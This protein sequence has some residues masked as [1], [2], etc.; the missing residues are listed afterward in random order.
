MILSAPTILAPWITFKPMVQTL[1]NAALL[2][3]LASAISGT[4]TCHAWPHVNDDACACVPHDGRKQ[5]FGV[6]PAERE[7]V[8]VADAGGP[9]FDPHFAGTRAV[10]VHAFNAEW[11]ASPPGHGCTGLHDVLQVCSVFCPALALPFG[12]G[13]GTGTARHAGLKACVKK[14]KSAAARRKLEALT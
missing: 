3:I 11:L 1:S 6:G 12:T 2:W 8:R 9:D 10:Q 7:L 4:T 5:A 14:G 13:T